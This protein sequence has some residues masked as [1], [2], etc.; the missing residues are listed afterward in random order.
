VNGL[1]GR[2]GFFGV[3][4][5]SLAGGVRLVQIPGGSLSVLDLVRMG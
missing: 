2:L 5:G 4:L 3:G 1:I